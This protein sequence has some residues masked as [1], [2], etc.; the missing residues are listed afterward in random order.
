MKSPQLLYCYL[1]NAPDPIGSVKSPQLLYCYL[2]QAP[3]PIRSVKAPQLVFTYNATAPLLSKILMIR[4]R[5]V[6][7]KRL[8]SDCSDEQAGGLKRLN[9]T[10]L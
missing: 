9:L 8:Q 2:G 1:S 6:G 3:D 4:R 7:K 5:K 10:D